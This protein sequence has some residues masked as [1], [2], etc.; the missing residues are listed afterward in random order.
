LP[1]TVVDPPTIE[2]TATEGVS[3]LP[4]T[5]GGPANGRTMSTLLAL[6]LIAFGTGAMAL[7]A[8]RR[9]SS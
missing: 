5:G 6:L 4:D 8:V 1:T 3:Q 2:P 9:R 7:F